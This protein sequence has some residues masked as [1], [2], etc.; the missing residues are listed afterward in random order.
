MELVLIATVALLAFANGA[1]DNFKGVA[2]LWGSGRASYSR[3]LTWATVCT[4]LG[5]LASL[6]LAGGLVARFNGSSL[7]PASS[8][9]QT[10]FLAAVALGAAAT[11]LLA[12]IMG[13]PVSTTHALTGALVG[14]GV[15]AAGAANVRYATL[16]MSVAAP[17]LFSPLV[18]FLLTIGLS[19]LASRWARSR[20][21]GD[22]LCLD[23]SASLGFP[24]TSGAAGVAIALPNLRVAPVEECRTGAEFVRITASGSMHWLSAAAISIARGVNDTPKI[25]ALLLVATAVSAGLNYALVAAAM[26]AGGVLGAARV[27]RTMSKRITPMEDRE[28]VTANLVAASLVILASGFAMPVS[29]THVTSGSIFGIG[30]LRR[31]EANWSCVREILLAWMVTLPLAGVL[32]ML[33]YA[34]LMK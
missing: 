33:F 25:V 9:S 31:G 14:G 7:I 32:A 21:A 27:A 13:L 28:A 24:S 2:T 22:C 5:S 12:S 30:L 4:L 17:L 10:Q 29:T 18:S 19:P 15:V 34:L 16:A 26:A 3:A 1:N 11:V 8:Y 6:W 20:G 23:E